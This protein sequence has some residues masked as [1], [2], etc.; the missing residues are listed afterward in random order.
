[1]IQINVDLRDVQTDINKITDLL[2]APANALV[3]PLFDDFKSLITDVFV[4]EGHGQWPKRKDNLIHP[5]LRKSYNLYT[6]IINTNHP[7]N[8]L[9]AQSHFI[10]IGTEVA[11]AGVHEYGAPGANIP[12]RP[13]FKLLVEPTAESRLAQAAEAYLERTLT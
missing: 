5:I 10:I 3:D 4:S 6:S 13:Y 11:Y 8:I 2:I 12:A 9:L 7:Q 1:M